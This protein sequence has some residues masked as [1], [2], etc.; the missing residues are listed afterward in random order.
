MMWV[1]GIVIVALILYLIFR[2]PTQSNAKPQKMSLSNFQLQADALLRHDFEGAY[3]IH[4]IK[5]NKWLVSSSPH[6]YREIKARI[7]GKVKPTQIRKD[8]RANEHFEIYILKLT[9]D[10]L[11]CAELRDKLEETYAAKKEKY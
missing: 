8:I 10:K 9:N 2:S 11:S 6:V 7:D 4:N 5:R 1:I 3:A